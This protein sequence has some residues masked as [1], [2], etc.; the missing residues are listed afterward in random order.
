VPAFLGVRLRTFVLA[1]F[2]GVIPGTFVY[3][4]VGA[5]LKTLLDSNADFSLGSVL[6]PQILTALIGLAL[7]SLLPVAYKAWRKSRGTSK[8]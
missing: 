6:T 1:T 5:G 3:T 8:K 4:T 7:L 2:I